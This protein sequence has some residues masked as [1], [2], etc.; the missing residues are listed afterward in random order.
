MSK[1]T[2][3]VGMIE[4]L[5]SRSVSTSDVTFVTNVNFQVHPVGMLPRRSALVVCQVIRRQYSESERTKFDWKKISFDLMR[6]II[7]EKEKSII[8]WQSQVSQQNGIDGQLSTVGHLYNLFSLDHT[9]R[10]NWKKTSVELMRE[11]INEKDKNIHDKERL[12]KSQQNAFDG[13]LSAVGRSPYDLFSHT[14]HN[15]D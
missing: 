6:E 10:M 2:S 15:Y 9:E 8:H 11:I 5:H 1:A 7:N 13:Q 14:N 3:R 4:E 12:I